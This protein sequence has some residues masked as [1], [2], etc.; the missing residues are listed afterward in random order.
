MS[1]CQLH[2]IL[3]QVI[4]F[5]WRAEVFG[6]CKHACMLSR[7]VV[8]Q[9]IWRFTTG[10]QMC[11]GSWAV[12]FMHAALQGFRAES[13]FFQHRGDNFCVNWFA[14]VRC[15][16]Q[17]DFLISETKMISRTG[18]DERQSLKW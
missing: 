10:S 2:G 9:H 16:S 17:C 5:E 3:S 11:C 12:G 13:D 1:D 7:A 4:R 15:A 18:N 14:I 8:V 6:D